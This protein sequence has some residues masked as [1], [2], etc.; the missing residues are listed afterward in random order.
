MVIVMMTLTLRNVNGME[1]IVVDRMFIHITVRFVHVM[2]ILK[3]Q[4]QLLQQHLQLLKLQL[5]LDQVLGYLPRLF[6]QLSDVYDSL[7]YSI[8][9]FRANSFCSNLGRK[10][11]LYPPFDPPISLMEGK[12]FLDQIW[13]MTD[14]FF[15]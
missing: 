9:T 2:K 5:Q 4:Q 8:V 13:A 11:V 12:Y 7:S 6:I 15:L 14:C 10:G 1:E 3:Q